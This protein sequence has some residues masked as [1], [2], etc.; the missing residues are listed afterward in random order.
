MMSMYEAAIIRQKYEK[1]IGLEKKFGTGAAWR[2]SL[3]WRPAAA[4]MPLSLRKPQKPPPRP[5][6]RQPTT[7]NRPQRLKRHPKSN[8]QVYRVDYAIHR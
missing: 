1:M 4:Q 2:A 7:D 6:N 3:A 5:D 8:L